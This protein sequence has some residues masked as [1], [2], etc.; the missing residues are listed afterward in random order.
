MSDKFNGGY[1]ML[2]AGGLD[3]SSAQAQSIT[4]SYNRA[5]T[6]MEAG[7]P[8]IA[9]NMVYGENTPTTPIPVFGWRISTT[10]VVLV[11]ATLHVHV[12]SD[13]TCTVLDVAPST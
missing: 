9:H 5:V 13:D 11:S 6:A 7:K 10:Q 3:L 2:D 1:V 8:I 4:G 12:S